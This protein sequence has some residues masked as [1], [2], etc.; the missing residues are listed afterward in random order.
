[1]FMVVN[2][3]YFVFFSIPSKNI[4]ESHEIQHVLE[5]PDLQTEIHRNIFSPSEVRKSA[6]IVRDESRFGNS[7][8]KNLE[9]FFFTTTF[10]SLFNVCKVMNKNTHFL[11][12]Y[13][14]NKKFVGLILLVSHVLLFELIFLFMLISEEV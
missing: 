1:M 5:N 14:N 11:F 3:H 9:K 13:N 7:T 4:K 10:Y 8:F 12:F 6:E 2:Y